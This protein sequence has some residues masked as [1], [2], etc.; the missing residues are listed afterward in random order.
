M[1]YRF[2]GRQAHRRQPVSLPVPPQAGK[3]NPALAA[4]VVASHHCPIARAAAIAVLG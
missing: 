4:K 3:P 1:I 2:T